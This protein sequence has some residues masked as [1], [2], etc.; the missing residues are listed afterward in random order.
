MPETQ[1]VR[2]FPIQDKL[3]CHRHYRNKRKYQI[4]YYGPAAFDHL[5]EIGQ[6]QHGHDHKVAG[7][8]HPVH[9]AGA[10]KH[11]VFFHICPLSFICNNEMQNYGLVYHNVSYG[12]NT[13]ICS[14]PDSW[15]ISHC[16]R[17]IPLHGAHHDSGNDNRRAQQPVGRLFFPEQKPSRQYRH[18]TARLF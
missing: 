5:H 3:N 2:L 6:L 16:L 15:Y 1:I 8:R 14:R 7:N 10:V 4:I 11:T 17:H 13:F 12:D 9:G 18:H